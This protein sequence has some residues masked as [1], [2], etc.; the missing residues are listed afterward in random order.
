[1]S[2][3]LLKPDGIDRIVHVLSKSVISLTR[4]KDVRIKRVDV[5]TPAAFTDGTTIS[6]SDHYLKELSAKLERGTTP[7]QTALLIARVKGFV[8]HEMAHC[9]YSPRSRSDIFKAAQYKNLGRSFNILEDQR[10]EYLLT[11][12]FRNHSKFLTVSTLDY[13]LRCSDNPHWTESAHAFIHGR[14]FLPE[15]I[16]DLA[17]RQ[18]AKGAAVADEI[19]DIIDEYLTLTFPSNNDRALQLIERFDQL[20][21]PD[22]ISKGGGGYEPN[23]TTSGSPESES[24]Q[25]ADRDKAEKN[26]ADK[27]QGNAGESDD[28]DDES[29]ESDGAGDADGDGDGDSDDEPINNQSSAGRQSPDSDDDDTD[30]GE[31]SDTDGGYGGGAGGEDTDNSVPLPDTDDYDSLVKKAFDDLSN[32]Q[33]IID[34]SHDFTE[35]LGRM[36]AEGGL[37]S[38][39]YVPFSKHDVPLQYRGVPQKV[40]TNLRKLT[41]KFRR[42]WQTGREQGKINVLAYQTRRA[43]DTNFFDRYQRGNAD[44]AAVEVVVLVD[45]SGSTGNLSSSVYKRYQEVGSSCLNEDSTAGNGRIVDYSALAGWAVKRSVDSLPN[46]RCTVY[47]FGSDPESNERYVTAGLLYGPNDKTEATSF[48]V[49]G[50]LKGS[51]WEGLGSTDPEWVIRESAKLFDGTR[52]KNRLL[53]IITDGSWDSSDPDQLVESYNKGGVKTALFGVGSARSAGHGVVAQ[54]GSHGCQYAADLYDTTDLPKKVEEL[55]A[56]M[57]SSRAVA[58][59]IR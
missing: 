6:L 49:P 54:Y 48:L 42:T 7:E 27:G 51:S 33:E 34:S 29:P 26:E 59:G 31:G 39:V 5:Y 11:G 53:V 44:A 18:F 57:L 38:N 15:D 40:S 22:A 2:K 14:R 25:R 24:Q 21:G 13:V 50:R 52:A 17:Y 55:V 43:G 8:Y 28:G 23:G 19:S 56:E 46:S 10:I 36:K 4:R 9:L 41:D 16:R 20:I 35:A 47:A 1:M 45:A 37:L 12:R 30:D 58:G 3:Q 32:D